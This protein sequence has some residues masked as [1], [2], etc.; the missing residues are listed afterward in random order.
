VTTEKKIDAETIKALVELYGPEEARKRLDHMMEYPR[1]EIVLNAPQFM[2][3]DPGSPEGDKTVL[4][5]PPGFSTPIMTPAEREP[6]STPPLSSTTFAGPIRV[7]DLKKGDVVYECER[8]RNL[9]LECLM[10]AFATHDGHKC[11]TRVCEPGWVEGMPFNTVELF[12]GRGA[13]HYG[14]K[15]Y[16]FPQYHEPA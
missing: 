13:D 7:R 3:V 2:G 1:A 12:T 8:G 11:V 15:L 16:R 5:P 14:P 9:K 6:D 10:D 4:T